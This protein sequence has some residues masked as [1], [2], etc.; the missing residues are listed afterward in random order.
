MHGLH[1]SG[2]DTLVK[3]ME[4]AEANATLNNNGDTRDESPGTVQVVKRPSPGA[5]R[6]KGFVCPVAACARVFS[7]RYNQ[8]AHMRLHDGTRPFSCS[9]CT[10]TFM[11]KSSLKSH[12]RM[13]AKLALS[14]PVPVL[15]KKPRKSK[16]AALSVRKPRGVSVSSSTEART[17]DATASAA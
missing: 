14:G 5:A 8:Q 6:A 17:E 1:V 11:W 4:A 13:H 7:K 15:A 3:A 9:L 10:K 12:A 16:S 2:L